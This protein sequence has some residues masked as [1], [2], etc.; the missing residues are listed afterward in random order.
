MTAEEHLNT[1][2]SCR[3]VSSKSTK[4]A[5][6]RN[7]SYSRCSCEADLGRVPLKLQQ[8]LMDAFLE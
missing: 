7:S 2:S 4:L 3:A 1:T 6:Q 8:G 5:D